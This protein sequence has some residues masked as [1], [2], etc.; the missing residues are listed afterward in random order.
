MMFDDGVGETTK[1][2]SSDP[3][4]PKDKIVFEIFRG[5]ISDTRFSVF[6]WV[7]LRVSTC[8]EKLDR[9]EPSKVSMLLKVVVY[10]PKNYL[11]SD[12]SLIIYIIHSSVV[13]SV[14]GGSP[15]V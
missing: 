13:V 8:Q 1:A 14:A 12:Y 2:F 10:I 6:R 9:I 15:Q 11:V 4:D 7:I 3:S 5:L